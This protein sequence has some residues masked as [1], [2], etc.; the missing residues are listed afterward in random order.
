MDFC[1]KLS[2]LQIQASKVAQADDSCKVDGTYVVTG[3]TG[4]V[5]Q[6]LCE[7][8]V[9]RGA[10]KVISFDIVPP[11]S[12]CWQSPKI[13]YIVGDLTDVE[14]I[15]NACKGV[16]AVFHIA[17]AVG[18]FHPMALYERVNYG[19]TLNVLAACK[20]N[21]VNKLVMSSSPSTRMTGVDVDGLRE[22]EMPQLPLPKYMQEYAKTK[23]MGEMAVTAAC[24][25]D[26][27]AVSVAP[28]Q[29]YG[30]RDNLFFPNI[31]EAAGTNMLRVFSSPRTGYGLNRV[32][33]THVDN[34]CHGLIC[35]L[36][37]LYPGSPALGKFYIV[38]DGRT[39]PFEAGYLHF[40]EAIDEAAVGL[41]FRSLTTR[42]KLPTWLLFPVA[43]LSSFVGWV[44]RRPM[45]LNPFNV[46]MLTM[47]RWFDITNSETDLKYQPVIPFADGW[48]DNIE[49]FKTNWLPNFHDTARVAGLAQQSAAK[50][51]VQAGTRAT[52]E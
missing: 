29:V 47:H 26:F 51:D 7:M 44:L 42:W 32:C 27:M 45:K 43:Y 25:G 20:S 16:D 46:R 49:W 3:G 13:E 30:P 38:T 4:F 19:G 48:K 33:F 15:T 2:A 24:D 31:M 34:Y 8:L 11:T 41:G 39:H 52:A 21:N 40:W 12:L 35:G 50:I 6:R 5:G 17:A 10:K 9:E 36:K 18:P 1:S 22:D 23:A 28:H 14:A 37:A